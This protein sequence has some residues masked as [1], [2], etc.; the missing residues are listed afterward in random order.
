MRSV[1]LPASDLSRVRHLGMFY[2]KSNSGISFSHLRCLETR[3]ESDDETEKQT[4]KQTRS[5]LYF[6][7]FAVTGR[8]NV[9]IQADKLVVIV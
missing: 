7:T 6:N 9:F 4:I 2:H 8:A 5:E 1:N 3:P